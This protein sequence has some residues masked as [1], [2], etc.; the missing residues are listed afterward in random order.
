MPKDDQLVL[1]LENQE[2]PDGSSN[3]LSIWLICMR[4]FLFQVSAA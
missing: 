4:L 1:V 3:C 2:A